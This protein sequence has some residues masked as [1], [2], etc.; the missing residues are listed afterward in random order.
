MRAASRRVGRLH[1][2]GWGFLYLAVG[3]PSD[4]YAFTRAVRL[5]YMHVCGD[6]REFKPTAP[7]PPITPAAPLRARRPRPPSGRGGRGCKFC[8]KPK[9]SRPFRYLIPP[10]YSPTDG[11]RRRVAWRSLGNADY[12]NPL[13]GVYPRELRVSVS[14]SSSTDPADSPS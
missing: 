8:D 1:T 4:V 14:I 12:F 3:T 10:P 13:D 2:G 6:G 7:F 5:R 9:I 11:L